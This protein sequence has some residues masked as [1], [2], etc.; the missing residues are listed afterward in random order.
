[1]DYRDGYFELLAE[2]S[3]LSAKNKALLT[4][5]Q[6]MI[7]ALSSDFDDLLIAKIKA[8]ALIKKAEGGA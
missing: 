3:T 2:R 5:L 6:E 4:A 8:Q 1:M 7:D